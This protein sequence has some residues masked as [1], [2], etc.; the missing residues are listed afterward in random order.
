MQRACKPLCGAMRHS[1]IWAGSNTKGYFVPNPNF[2][3]ATLHPVSIYCVHGT[4]D[5]SRSFLN[6]A[7][8]LCPDHKAIMK[9]EIAEL[10]ENVD[11]IYMVPFIR[12]AKGASIEDFAEQLS[13]FIQAKPSREV[14][15]VGHSRGGIVA[16]WFAEMIAPDVGVN[17]RMIQCVNSPWLGSKLA[18]KLIAWLSSSVEQMRVGSTFLANL[19]ARVQESDIPYHYV[20]SRR[21]QIVKGDAWKPEFVADDAPNTLFLEDHGH[22]SVMSSKRL[23]T[24]IKE[25]IRNIGLS[26][27]EN[28]RAL[29]RL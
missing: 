6:M 5:R 13:E 9:G 20:G 27:P 22:L 15:L 19:R 14:V 21:D 11:G 28:F 29:V 10:A 12:R 16:S 4:A 24:K 7:K 18:W 26:M 3:P 17:V 1:C 8:K 2:D 25:N 23:L